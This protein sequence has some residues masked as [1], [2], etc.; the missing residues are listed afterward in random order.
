M[1][2][3]TDDVLTGLSYFYEA[4]IKAY[5][6]FFGHKWG[7]WKDTCGDS[8]LG[9]LRECDRCGEYGHD[10]QALKNRCKPRPTGKEE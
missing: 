6:Y 4:G 8:P 3:F 10:S 1:S 5:C 9:Q 7:E 2:P